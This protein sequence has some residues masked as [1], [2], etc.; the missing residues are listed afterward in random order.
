MFSCLS[1]PIASVEIPKSLSADRN[2]HLWE[3]PIEKKTGGE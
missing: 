1:K 2:S 3:N